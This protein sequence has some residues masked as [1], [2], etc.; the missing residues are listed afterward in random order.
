LTWMKARGILHN[1]RGTHV[2]KLVRVRHGT[3]DLERTYLDVI[4]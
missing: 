2:A 4:V 3:Y 1:G